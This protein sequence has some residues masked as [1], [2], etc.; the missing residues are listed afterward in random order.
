MKKLLFIVLETIFLTSNLWGQE[1][2]TA[3]LKCQYKFNYELY[4]TEKKRVDDIILLIGHQYSK[5]YSY[6]TA[7]CDSLTQTPDG[8]KIW[9]KI[10]FTTGSYPHK[11]SSWFIYK[12]YPSGNNTITDCIFT[13]NFKYT[14]VKEEFHWSLTD[15]TKIILDYPCLLAT[16]E[17]RG[18]KYNA[19]FTTE[20]PV[21]NGPW[22]FC[23]LP[24][25]IMEVSDT[26]D[27]YHFTINA[28]EKTNIPIIISQPCNGRF[29]KT[30][31]K[32][33]QQAQMK[34]LQ[35]MSGY[36]K[37]RTNIDLGDSK[38]KAINDFMEIDYH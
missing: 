29:I 10:F 16:C 1:I 12:D 17:Y 19:W 18:R 32:K 11:R 13:D 34:F 21:Q 30:E 7:F 37:A 38:E 9:S 20:I 35:N 3:Y 5:C 26:N 22:K 6:H 2:D 33:F 25:L 36:L 31:R 8:D 28:I 15:S 14:E 4:T 24:G 27:L 23:G